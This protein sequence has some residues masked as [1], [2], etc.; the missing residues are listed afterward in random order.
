[1]LLDLESHI[2]M[3]VLALA[4]QDLWLCKMVLRLDFDVDPT[5]KLSCEKIRN[6]LNYTEMSPWGFT[7]DDST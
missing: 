6:R 1:M 2:R 7:R 3:S 4:L 5:V